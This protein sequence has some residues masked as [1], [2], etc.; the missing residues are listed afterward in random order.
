MHSSTYFAVIFGDYTNFQQ[1]SVQKVTERFLYCIK[2]ISLV[3]E[4]QS[5]KSCSVGHVL[6]VCVGGGGVGEQL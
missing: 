3:L 4:V 1:L 6:C 5:S 2:N